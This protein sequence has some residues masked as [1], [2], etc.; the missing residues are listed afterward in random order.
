[1]PVNFILFKNALHR[2]LNKVSSD[3]NNK[4]ISDSAADNSPSPPD[5]VPT[6]LQQWL[7]RV[8]QGALVT[9]RSLVR[10]VFASTLGSSSEGSRHS[11]RAL[12]HASSID[13]TKDEYHEHL[14][15]AD[16]QRAK[17]IK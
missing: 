16:V 7:P 13:A 8:P 11:E 14:R 9:L 1:M 3:P 6:S 12:T 15:K 4:K 2:I 10:D 5:A 17:K